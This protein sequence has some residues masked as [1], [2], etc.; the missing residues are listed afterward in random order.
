MRKSSINLRWLPL[1]YWLPQSECT[2]GRC[3]SV[4]A[5]AREEQVTSYYVTRVVYLAFLAPD[6][7]QRIVRG[8]HPLTLNATRLI[9]AVPLPLAWDEQRTRLGLLIS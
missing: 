6:I 1:A 8:E 5:N 3:N 9:R 2:S 7:V 4:H